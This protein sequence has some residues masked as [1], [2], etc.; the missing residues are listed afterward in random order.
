M[1][2]AL[3]FLFAFASLNVFAYEDRTFSCKNAHP[4]LP[5]N[6]YT[7]R[8]LTV[9]G[10][11]LPFVHAQR[12]HKYSD[13]EQI[14]ESS[15]KG[16]AVAATVGDREILSVNQLHLEFVDGELLNCKQ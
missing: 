3:I 2:I 13:S 7:I 4:E 9:D 10:V 5:N 16:F 15:I 12:F 11:E 8:V 1:K 6:T 14:S